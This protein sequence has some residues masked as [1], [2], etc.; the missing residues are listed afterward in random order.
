MVLSPSCK[1]PIKYCKV[2][3]FIV[4]GTTILP[5]GRGKYQPSMKRC[6]GHWL[7]EKVWS[8]KHILGKDELTCSIS[9]HVF[10]L[11]GRTD[12]LILHKLRKGRKLERFNSDSMGG[13]KQE[14]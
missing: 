6:Q 3:Q 2:A 13:C 1:S 4:K 5:K 14:E 8:L 10:L 7:R 11:L 12:V 9:F